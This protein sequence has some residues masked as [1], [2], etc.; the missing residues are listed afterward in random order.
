[1]WFHIPVKVHILEKDTRKR[2]CT[3]ANIR[4]QL[5]DPELKGP[6]LIIKTASK[7]IRLD[8]SVLASYKLI[9]F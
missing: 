5:K 2:T 7:T 4:L 6:S 9:Q 8:V 1:M 3:K